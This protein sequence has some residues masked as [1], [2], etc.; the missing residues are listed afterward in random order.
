MRDDGIGRSKDRLGVPGIARE[1]APEDDRFRDASLRT[2]T[3]AWLS[4]LP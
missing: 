4:S 2:R 3:V 1:T